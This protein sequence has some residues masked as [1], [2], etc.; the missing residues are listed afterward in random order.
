MANKIQIRRDTTANWNSVNPILS[1][2]E[3]GLD[4]T[5]HKIKI[6]NGTSQWSNLSFFIGDTGATGLTGAT[7]ATGP[8]G[9]AG[10][11]NEMINGNYTV[12]LNTNGTI[13][14]PVKND[15]QLQIDGSELIG[16]E[17]SPI[18]LS[19]YS[20]VVI[21]TY[22]PALHTWAFDNNGTLTVPG[23]ITNGDSTLNMQISGDVE[24]SAARRIILD[25]GN[26]LSQL[27]SVYVNAL[28]ELEALFYEFS[29]LPGYPWGITLPVSHLTYNEILQLPPDTISP[30]AAPIAHEVTISYSIWQE[31]VAA[32]SLIINV[33]SNTWEFNS[34]GTTTFPTLSVDLHNGGV[35]S[36]Q[37][38]KFDDPTKQVIIT[39]PTP[40]S[41]SSAQR[42]IVQGQRGTG[43]GEG[44]DVYIWGGD[45]DVNGGD[46]KIYAGDSDVSGSGGY[47]NIDGGYGHTTGGDITLSAGNSVT[48]GG[49]IR[50]TAGS[51]TAPGHITLE[52][53]YH[54]LT[55]STTGSLILP[56]NSVIE[57]TTGSEIADADI[58]YTHA[59]ATWENMRIN[60]FVYAIDNNPSITLEGWPFAGWDNVNGTNAQSYINI[61]NQAWEI[62]NDIPSSPPAPLLFYP[63]ISANM[64]TQILTALTTILDFYAD[65]QLLLSSVSITAGTNSLS[66]LGNGKLQV[67][68][69]IQTTT[70]ENLVI[71][72]R[73]LS[74][75]S[76]PN[77]STYTENDFTF[78]TNGTLTFP[79]ATIQTTAWTGNL[80]SA[81]RFGWE[82]GKYSQITND[83]VAIGNQAGRQNQGNYAVGLGSGA[84]GLNQGNYAIAIGVLT[85]HNTQGSNAI[86]IG[87]YAGNT[88]Q[89]ANA[90]A[91]GFHAGPVSQHANSIILNASGVDLSSSESGFFVDPVRNVNYNNFVTYDTTTKELT[92]RTDLR[93]E[94]SWTLTTGS[95]TVSFQVPVNGTY[96]MWVKGIVNNGVISWNATAT[97]TNANLPALG[98]QFAYVYSGAGS[99]LDFTTLPTQLVGTA[100]T[101]VRDSSTRG[102]PSNVFE[103]VINNTSGSS[104]SVSW[105]YTKI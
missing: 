16:V 38:L 64:H 24:L 29:S 63:A 91:I 78:G 75:A 35:Q 28:V 19:S 65:H 40:A 74:M 56:N 100:G 97:I 32:D 66:V 17:D 71:R 93:N 102:T 23:A 5:L 2:G 13:S 46:I 82:A 54:Q 62:Q 41:G 73:Y 44:G 104:Q 9:P 11:T 33:S 81:I 50:I 34:T 101:I 18:A 30:S 92:Y 58:K 85:G 15:T 99:L 4:T 83:P 14:F 76:P 43:S 105:G 55:L 31:R 68:E 70:E 94:G 49:N 26:E 53:N 98:Q 79:D 27:E 36:G 39:G 45:S 10:F 86:A 8:Q 3:L 59:I 89:G 47:V 69:I 57:P 77:F 60:E 96:T 103:F 52:S 7:G 90:I 87:A 72:T 48:N 21:N 22:N 84:G 61:V 80:A 37:V 67:P 6:G 51:G 88:S 25:T 95:N 1:Q 12:T 42:I 20:S